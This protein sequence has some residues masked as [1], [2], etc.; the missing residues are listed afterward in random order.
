[1]T[2]HDG[3][4]TTKTQVWAKV[5][6]PGG[7][8]RKPSWTLPIGD[9]GGSPPQIKPPIPVRPTP[10]PR[11]STSSTNKVPINR[12]PPPP[13]TIIVTQKAT[14]VAAATPPVAEASTSPTVASTVSVAATTISES[15]ASATQP[16]NETKNVTEAMLTPPTVTTQQPVQNNLVLALVPIMVATI[17]LT[18]AGVLACLF[19]KR[20]FSAKVKSK[21]VNSIVSYN[22]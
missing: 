12:P 7:G 15:T 10:L 11:P 21:K 2:V 8:G 14:T 13:P 19:R 16:P 20:L 3:H 17:V 5:E 1:M 22:I 6:G 4:L 9:G 18:T